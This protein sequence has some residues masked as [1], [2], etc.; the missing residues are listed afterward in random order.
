MAKVAEQK[1][2]MPVK[3]W[4]LTDGNKSKQAPALLLGSKRQ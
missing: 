1:N 4:R 3:E 2:K